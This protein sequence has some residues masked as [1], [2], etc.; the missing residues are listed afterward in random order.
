M[1]EV[2]FR[3]FAMAVMQNQIPAAASHL[4]TLLGLSPA[5]AET[6]AMHFKLRSSDPAFLPKAMSL[7]TAVTTGSDAEIGELLTE[8]F[9]LADGARAAAIAK[10]HENYPR[11]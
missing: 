5:A 1:P 2:T 10:I 3:D 6:A 9:G 8:C 11:A 4:E 7:R